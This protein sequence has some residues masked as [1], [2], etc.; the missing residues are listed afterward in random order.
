MNKNL[1]PENAPISTRETINALQFENQFPEVQQRRGFFSQLKV[2]TFNAPIAAGTANLP[3][4]GDFAF[5]TSGTVV[6]LT[7][8]LGGGTTIFYSPSGTL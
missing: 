8:G 3:N 2:K 1:Q 4:R 5:Q 7:V 6:V